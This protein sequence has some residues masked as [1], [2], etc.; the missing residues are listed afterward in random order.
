MKDCLLM[1]HCHIGPNRLSTYLAAVSPDLGLNVNALPFMN[2]LP[3][4][5]GTLLH[6]TRPSFAE[7]LSNKNPSDLSSGNVQCGGQPDLHQ[8]NNITTAT[9]A[10]SAQIQSLSTVNEL[11]RLCPDVNVL[12]TMKVTS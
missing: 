4:T 11:L 1:R 10:S 6:L 2:P 8:M 9:D 12:L 5:S 3:S 7:A